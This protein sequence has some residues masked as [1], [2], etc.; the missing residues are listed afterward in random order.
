MTMTMSTAM[1]MVMTT[2]A[3]MNQS[4]LLVMIRTAMT[5]MRLPMAND[6]NNDAD[7]DDTGGVGEDDYADGDGDGN[8]GGAD[9]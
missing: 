9:D 7:G 5:W 1:L 3:M 2:V 6:D 4:M 8:A